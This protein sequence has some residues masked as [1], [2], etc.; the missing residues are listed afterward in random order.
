MTMIEL[1]ARAIYEARNGRGC[2]PWSKRPASHK[3]PY[4]YEAR[5]A[6]EAMREPSEEMVE[7]GASDLSSAVD[8]AV[9]Y[10]DSD[11]AWRV[12]WRAEARAA[13]AAMIKRAL[14]G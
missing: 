9:V 1:V 2:V 8:G 3:A 12:E 11:A 14:E 5:A 13:Y 6:I 4:L 10:D 7:A